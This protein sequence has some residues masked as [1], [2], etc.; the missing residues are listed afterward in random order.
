MTVNLEPAASVD[1]VSDAKDV[2]RTMQIVHDPKMAPIDKY[3]FLRNQQRWAT[4][5]FVCRRQKPP[6]LSPSTLLL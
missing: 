6:V 4:L 3:M 1:H 2:Q 5:N